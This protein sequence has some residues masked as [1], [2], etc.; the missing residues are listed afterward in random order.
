[1]MN[2][3]YGHVGSMCSQ[4]GNTVRVR[5]CSCAG[6]RIDLQQAVERLGKRDMH[7]T[8]ESDKTHQIAK[9]VSAFGQGGSVAQ[10]L[11]TA[12]AQVRATQ[13]MRGDRAPA[14]VAAAANMPVPVD[15]TEGAL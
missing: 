12:T 15:R 6:A 2:R 9:V 8:N 4:D 7:V 13:W 14:A 5:A 10:L 3:S 11:K 1:M